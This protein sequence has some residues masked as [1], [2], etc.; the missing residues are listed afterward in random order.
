MNFKLNEAIEL[1]ERTPKTLEVFL[2]GLS[3][4][5]LGCNEGEGTWNTT[6]VVDHLI[7]AEKNNWMPRLECILQEGESRV[8]SPLT[9]LPT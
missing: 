7:E 3:G 8:F 1:L 2:S 4:K 5:W 9:G 6:E